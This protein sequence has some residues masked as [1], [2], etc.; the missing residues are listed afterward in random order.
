MYS[1]KNHLTG[2]WLLRS[3]IE[4]Q[5]GG[6]E[7]LFP[8]GI[9]PEGL[10]IYTADGCMSLQ[11]ANAERENY[12]DGDRFL[13]KNEEFIAS[14]LSF[15]A[16][17]GNYEILSDNRTLIHH[18]QISSFPNWQGL[19]Q[20]RSVEIDVDFLYL[21]TVDPVLSNGLWVNSYMTWQKMP[22]TGFFMT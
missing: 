1:L 18:M 12:I 16:Y 15:I 7:S 3:Y 6:E 19:S 20:K 21:K 5:V 17:T 9:R 10:L 8:F 2:S 4:V 22:K 14:A 11:I 13:A